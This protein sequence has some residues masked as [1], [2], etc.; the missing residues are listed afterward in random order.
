LAFGTPIPVNASVEFLQTPKRLEITDKLFAYYT[1]ANANSVSVFVSAKTGPTFSPGFYTPNVELS[2]TVS[3]LFG[4][5]END[6]TL[7]Y[8]T[9]E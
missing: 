7:L 6:G 1:G 2:G 9:I 5:T 3:A 8:Y 4:T